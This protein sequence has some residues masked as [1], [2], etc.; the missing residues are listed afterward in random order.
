MMLYYFSH[1]NY[2]ISDQKQGWKYLSLFTVLDTVVPYSR[3]AILTRAC[4][5]DSSHLG[6]PICMRITYVWMECLVPS[7]WD[8]EMEVCHW[9][10]SLR[11]QIP[12]F[13]N[14]P[15]PLSLPLSLRLP[16]SPSPSPSLSLSASLL[17]IKVSWGPSVKHMRQTFY[18][19]TV[20]CALNSK[21]LISKLIF[22]I[23]LSE[24]LHVDT[25]HVFQKGFCC[26]F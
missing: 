5:W 15:L 1:Y 14:L 13:P 22:M 21:E 20:A 11:F 16:L 10:W 12:C 4:H 17:R 8:L 3:K 9:R 6:G 2:Q 26:L 7:W 18:F 24:G 25:K 23:I 19:W